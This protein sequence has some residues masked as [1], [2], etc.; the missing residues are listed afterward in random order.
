[1]NPFEEF[2]RRLFGGGPPPTMRAE[3]EEAARMPRVARNMPS[4]AADIGKSFVDAYKQRS[5]DL[6]DLANRQAG[7]AFGLY[8]PLSDYGED[9]RAAELARAQRDLALDVL[10]AGAMGPA[11]SASMGMLSSA[12]GIGGSTV[13]NA[14]IDVLAR[15]RQNPLFANVREIDPSL[16]T[17][18]QFGATVPEARAV[19]NEILQGRALRPEILGVQQIPVGH[20]SPHFFLDPRIDPATARTG[21]GHQLWG[22]GLYVFENPATGESYRQSLRKYFGSPT[23]AGI[24][25]DPFTVSQLRQDPRYKE[26]VDR[27]IGSRTSIWDPEDRKAIGKIERYYDESRP[28]GLNTARRSLDGYRGRV[29]FYENLVFEQKSLLQKAQQRLEEILQSETFSPELKQTLSRGEKEN[30]S[31]LETYI[32]EAQE[33]VANAKKAYRKELKAFGSA[34]TRAAAKIRARLPE[35]ST[36]TYRGTFGANPREILN[37]AEPFFGFGRPYD[38]PFARALLNLPGGEEKL[39]RYARRMDALNNQI[40]DNLPLGI[41]F[42]DYKNLDYD[43]P[44]KNYARQLESDVTQVQQNL[45]KGFEPTYTRSERSLDP[46]DIMGAMMDQGIVGTK[47]PDSGSRGFNVL[48]PTGMAPSEMPTFNYTIYDP[49]RIQFQSAFAANPL[50]PLPSVMSQMQ[51][52]KEKKK[53]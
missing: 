25:F 15:L 4:V 27:L 14:G 41:S 52:D 42:E 32:K 9:P 53:K 47:F 13:R 20:S 24:P 37:Q 40:F 44:I 2:L 26:F 18:L 21:E 31:A 19:L 7:G 17:Y 28:S 33:S 1:M 36:V 16:A 39:D 12:P 35:A 38:T 6:Q 34:E 48:K 51:K 50:L 10:S 3:E 46:N 11:T 29:D 45:I 43:D 22:P 49:N 5:L 30:I 23:L 8:Q